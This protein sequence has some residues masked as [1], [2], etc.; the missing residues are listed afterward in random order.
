MFHCF[1]SWRFSVFFFLFSLSFV[2]TSS[3]WFL[4]CTFQWNSIEVQMEEIYFM[5]NN[6]RIVQ[7][8]VISSLGFLNCSVVF[9]LQKRF[10]FI[11]FFI[12]FFL[13]IFLWFSFPLLHASY[14]C[15]LFLSMCFV[16]IEMNL[17]FVVFWFKMHS[18]CKVFYLITQYKLS[19]PYRGGNMEKI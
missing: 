3:W 9:R 15:I 17:S 10:S 8:G 19:Y 14:K 18:F 6:S 16:C 7:L 13:R 1:S 2:P 4:M 5:A 12:L 11:Y